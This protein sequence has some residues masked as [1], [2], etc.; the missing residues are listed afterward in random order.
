MSLEPSKKY[1]KEKLFISLSFDR[2]IA[3]KNNNDT[4]FPGKPKEL[5]FNC[6]GY[7]LNIE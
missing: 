5:T 7:C 6:T 3:K 4:H 2:E 1:Y